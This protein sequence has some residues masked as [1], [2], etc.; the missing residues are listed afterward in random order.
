MNRPSPKRSRKELSLKLKYE[1]IV[2]SEKN[3]RPTQKDFAVQFEIGKTTVSDIL[4]RKEV[5]TRTYEENTTS[6]RKRHDTGNKYG[7][8]NEFVYQWF[9]QA[10]AK[11]F[12]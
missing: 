12:I 6:K 1:L 3:P 8:L 10:R 2:E 7:E 4:K 5:Y 11:T 9:K